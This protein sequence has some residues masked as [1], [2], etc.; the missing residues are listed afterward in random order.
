MRYR[1][2]ALLVVA[3][4]CREKAEKPA[5]EAAVVVVD[6]T[7]DEPMDVQEITDTFLPETGPRPRAASAL[8]GLA[9]GLSAWSREDWCRGTFTGTFTASPPNYLVNTLKRSRE[10]S[11]RVVIIWPRRLMTSNGQNDGRFSVT[12]ARGLVDQF[13]KTLSEQKTYVQAG[14][15][16]G[17]M[18]LDD[19]ACMRCWGGQGISQAEAEGL[20]SYAKQKLPGVPL[21]I[22]AQPRW[23]KGR[24]S[25]SKFID[26]G[27]AQYTLSKG[28][29]KEFYDG[30]ARDA[31]SLPYPMKLAGGINVYHFSKP[32]NG[33]PITATELNTIGSYLIEHHA[34]CFSTSWL[35]WD[36]WQLNGRGAVTSNLVAKGKQETNVPSCGR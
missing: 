18:P 25:L 3:L 35:A 8:S 17:H 14:T 4:G 24:P 34:I 31:Q 6:S 12:K 23:V 11:V 21:G 5:E 30:A 9:F 15:F 7:A 1:W 19:V 10:C 36:G 33:R 27:W 2:L 16:I 13:A 22:R 20:Y 28:P 29:Y 26:F 32:F